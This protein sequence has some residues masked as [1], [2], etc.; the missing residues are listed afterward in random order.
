LNSAA[1]LVFRQCEQSENSSSEL[2]IWK[3]VNVCEGWR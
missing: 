2:G 1:F 3:R